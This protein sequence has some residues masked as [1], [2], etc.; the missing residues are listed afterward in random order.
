MQDDRGVYY[1]PF[2][3]NRQTRVYVKKSKGT[4][5]FRLWS[6]RTVELWDEHGWVPHNAIKKA[7]SMFGNNNN[8]DP[9]VVYDIEVA[10]ELI[11]IAEKDAFNP[12]TGSQGA[13]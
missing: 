11:R 1:H 4:I 12:S 8:F 5:W 6:S 2:P 9:G 10:R 7:A 3:R 13:N